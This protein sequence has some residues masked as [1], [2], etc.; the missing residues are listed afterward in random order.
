MLIGN[1]R[2][3]IPHPTANAG[4]KN[5]SKRR[6][7][8]G[9]GKN[10]R[11]HS[12]NTHVRRLRRAVGEEALLFRSP[13]RWSLLTLLWLTLGLGFWLLPFGETWV[14]HFGLVLV[15]AVSFVAGFNRHGVV[16]IV[17]SALVMAAASLYA[18]GGEVPAVG[19]GVGLAA[20]GLFLMNSHR[21]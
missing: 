13:I 17:A 8:S 10:I 15:L 9:R 18:A 20:L 11:L 3:R 21:L 6:I 4:F 7:R 19:I 1:I 5:R 12:Q 2:I 16:R 14:P